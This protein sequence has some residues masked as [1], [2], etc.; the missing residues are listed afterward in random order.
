MQAYNYVVS[1]LL[2]YNLPCVC[3][4]DI[5]AH[6]HHCCRGWRP[7]PLYHT[8][9]G[10]WV[11]KWAACWGRS[12]YP[13]SSIWILS[14]IASHWRRGAYPP[15]SIWIFSLIA[16]HWGRGAY[17]PS[18]VW[19]IHCELDPIILWKDFLDTVLFYIALGDFFLN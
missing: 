13:P 19:I 11:I 2:L 5:S 8:T 10:I 3:G 14:V 15:S 1:I 7:W 12:S 16:G 17:P 9:V 6:A 18:C 4:V